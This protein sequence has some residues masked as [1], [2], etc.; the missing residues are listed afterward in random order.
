MKT[1]KAL[2]IT[3]AFVFL[4]ALAFADPANGT[5][6]NGTEPEQKPKFK[7][8]SMLGLHLLDLF[9]L[10]PVKQDTAVTRR[11]EVIVLPESEEEE[12]D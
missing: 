4:S 10:R 7:A 11:I 12:K 1:A 3:F 2:S 9:M 8:T 5:D 6:G